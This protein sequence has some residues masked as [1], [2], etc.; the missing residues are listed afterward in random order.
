MT[1][2][3]VVVV[4]LGFLIFGVWS[5][6][7]QTTTV[8][9]EVIG[10]TYR[11]L[12]DGKQML[13]E[14]GRSMIL[15]MPPR[16]SIAL[17][18]RPGVPSLPNP[19]GID[20]VVVTD[21][22]GRLLFRDDFDFFDPTR[23][24]VLTGTYDTRDGVL[25]GT[26]MGSDHT[27]VLKGEGWTDYIVTVTYKNT[28]PA[29]ITVRRTPDGGRASYGLDL[30]RD[31]PNY[32]E[33][34]DED[35]GWQGTFAGT[36]VHT[37]SAE[38][39]KSISAMVLKPYPLIFLI[40]A[41]GGLATL[42]LAFAESGLARSIG[43][44]Q[45]IPEAWL[46]PLPLARYAWLAFVLVVAVG[47]FAATLHIN[48]KYYQ[49]PHVPDE[50]SYMYEAKLL[51][52]LQIT[53]TA[54]PVKEAFYFWVPVFV[55]ESGDQWST[56]YPFGHP[57]MLAPGELID[58]VWL[59]PPLVG[60]ACVLLLFLVGRRIYDSRTAAL[61]AVLMAASPFFLMHS[62]NWMSH[63]TWL[64]Y[65][66]LSWLFLLD[67]RRSILSGAIAGLAFGL[68][69]NT[70]TLETA[71][72][73]PVWGLILLSYLR[74]KPGR[75]EAARFIAAFL[76][77]GLLMVIAMLGYNAA[78]TGNP[79][80]AP[81]TRDGGASAVLG[82]NDGFTFD[83]GL[84]N[85]QAELMSL[86][87]VLNG[88][89][90]FVGLGLVLLPFICGTRNVW[91]YF[92]LTSI[93]L[94]TGIYVLYRYSGLYEGPRYWFQTMPFL[95]FLAARGAEYAVLLISGGARQIRGRLLNDWRPPRWAGVAVVYAFLAFLVID[96]TG[97]WL[98]GWNDR[99]NEEDVPQ[100]QNEVSQLRGIYGVDNSFVEIARSQKIH[101]ALILVRPCGNFASVAC[102]SSVFLEN[103]V[104]YNGDIVW[105]RWIAGRNQDIIEAF[106][107]RRVYVASH[108]NIPT[109][110]AYVAGVDRE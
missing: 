94:V 98:I 30:M 87:L 80:N 78:I 77:G 22:Q 58:A 26:E 54:P 8:R 108:D 28:M 99:W 53:D 61:A 91:D 90:A 41:V 95:M 14:T 24:Q 23:W 51:A 37:H 66:L 16:G 106:P 2:A 56:L 109:I 97:G 35:G 47:L 88:W 27:I 6:G 96:G 32:V 71:M 105:A 52:H 57:L 100:V 101:N 12:A 31:F 102:Y 19:Q 85:Q 11:V 9:V 10:D 70:R 63:I 69:L 76:V 74:L 50:V 42:A 86:L 89:P 84:R 29:G 75:V 15:A 60:A 34:Y 4:N 72:L 64:F 33:V 45:L 68:A 110:E 81:Y 5:K 48:R 40:V 1:L 67:K 13:P 39:I 3:I 43:R 83:I 73:I 65:V 17:S 36:Y 82:F 104:A 20:S 107:G 92:C 93:L 38:V 55:Y 49:V 59:I 46:S 25:D 62:S 103:N 7:G 21:P 79:L 44:P 18:I